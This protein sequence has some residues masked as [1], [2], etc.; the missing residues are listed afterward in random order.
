[1]LKWIAFDPILNVYISN[2]ISQTSITFQGREYSKEVIHPDLIHK[3]KELYLENKSNTEILDTLNHVVKDMFY[4]QE[5]PHPNRRR[6]FPNMKDIRNI[7]LRVKQLSAFSK[8]E[9]TQVQA[10]IDR[11]R[12]EKADNV[13]LQIDEKNKRE[14][15]PNTSDEESENE[16]DKSRK[17]ERK[18]RTFFFCHQ[19]PL[20]QKLMKRYGQEAAYLVE[21]KDTMQMK[22]I[23]TYKMY[24]LL[25]QTNVDFQVVGSLI[26]SKRRKEGLIECLKVFREWNSY[27]TPRYFMVDC[28]ESIYDAIEVCFPSKVFF[29]YFCFNCNE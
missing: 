10:V 8:E 11:I 2:C 16:G 3:A 25:V 13:I 24:A 17:E 15:K 4:N 20:Q 12:T 27:W 22:R 29:V 5:L 23:L 28:C 19:T 26:T 9:E 6:Y 21:V 7:N 18:A 1:M 14:S